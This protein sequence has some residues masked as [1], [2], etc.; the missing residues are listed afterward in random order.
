MNV[1]YR[2]KFWHKNCLA[3]GLSAGF[4]EPLE[5]TA[6]MLVEA[7]TKLLVEQFPSTRASMD[8]AANQVNKITQYGWDRVIDFIKLHYLFES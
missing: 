6:I 8:L 1:G 7:T 5:A 3:I 2:E 4:L